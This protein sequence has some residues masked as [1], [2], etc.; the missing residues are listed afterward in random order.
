[1]AVKCSM[2]SFSNKDNDDN[3]KNVD[4][5]ISVIEVSIFTSWACMRI[6]AKW[7]L[8]NNNWSICKKDCD[9][10]LFISEII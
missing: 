8:G 1:M 3:E 7:K 4:V 2:I 10:C 6:Q 9:C 5:V